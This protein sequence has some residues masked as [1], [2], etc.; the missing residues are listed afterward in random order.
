MSVKQLLGQS[1]IQCSIRTYSLTTLQCQDKVS[2]LKESLAIYS[3]NLDDNR[4]S[5]A[6][7]WFL[8]DPLLNSMISTDAHNWLKQQ[9]LA[10][11][12]TTPLS[13]YLKKLEYLAVTMISEC[14]LMPFY[15][16]WQSL[17]FQDILQDVTM[18]EWG[19]PDIRECV[20]DKTEALKP[21]KTEDERRVKEIHFFV[22]KLDRYSVKAILILTLSKFISL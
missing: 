19:W 21:E 13:D 11:R 20:D 7:R 14:W 5:S 17:Y 22:S 12:Q 15:H 4:P 9:L 6:F 2:S 1:G 18:T 8:S 3:T 16:Q 10:I